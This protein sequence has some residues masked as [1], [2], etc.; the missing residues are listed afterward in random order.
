MSSI[1]NNEYK[2]RKLNL[3]L[4]ELVYNKTFEEEM[5]EKR[6]VSIAEGYLE[7]LGV[8]VRT[9]MYGYYRNT[10]DILLDLGEY[11]D[12]KQEYNYSLLAACK[13]YFGDE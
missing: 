9:D 4:T 8:K 10:Y 6:K 12:G 1:S 3:N 5:E 2:D 7:G 13:K 11:L